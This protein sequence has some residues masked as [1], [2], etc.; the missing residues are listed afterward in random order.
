MTNDLKGK[1]NQVKTGIVT[2][3][4]LSKYSVIKSLETM[5]LDDTVKLFGKPLENRVIR[6]QNLTSMPKQKLLSMIEKDTIIY[7]DRVK[8][9][10]FENIFQ[11][12]SLHGSIVV[13]WDSMNLRGTQFSIARYFAKKDGLCMATCNTKALLNFAMGKG[14]NSMLAKKR[15]KPDRRNRDEVINNPN[16]I[17]V[18]VDEL[19]RELEASKI[20]LGVD[21]VFTNLRMNSVVRSMD[22]YYQEKIRQVEEIY[23]SNKDKYGKAIYDSYMQFVI[24]RLKVEDRLR[25]HILGLKP[26]W[27]ELMSKNTNHCAPYE[28]AQETLSFKQTI[29]KIISVLYTEQEYTEDHYNIGAVC[30]LK[31]IGIVNI[32]LAKESVKA[33]LNFRILPKIS[34]SLLADSLIM[35]NFPKLANDG[36]ISSNLGV[37]KENEISTEQWN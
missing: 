22:P 24:I 30:K 28:S 21:S 27:I 1:D 32:V 11:G 16:I 18:D 36:V 2:K 13:Y 17:E 15:E 5:T 7:L 29:R 26:N 14:A 9:S 37:I 20:R 25:V 6:N 34:A 35:S 31:D 4:G 23:N 3:T 33:R 19:V 10:D 8:R 12:R